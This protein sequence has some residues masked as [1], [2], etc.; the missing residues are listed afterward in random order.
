M[1]NELFF[2]ENDIYVYGIYYNKIEKVC[3]EICY[4]C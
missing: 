3:F 2:E 1:Y 4:C